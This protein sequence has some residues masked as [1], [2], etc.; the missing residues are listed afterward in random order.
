MFHDEK[1]NRE[2]N[3]TAQ[4][5]ECR[6]ELSQSQGFAG[7]F[8]PLS[9][10]AGSSEPEPLQSLQVSVL[11]VG[12]QLLVE[13]RQPLGL[14]REGHAVPRHGVP[15]PHRQHVALVVL[16][17]QVLQHSRVVD[18]GVQ[19]VLLDGAEASLDRLLVVF[20][21]KRRGG[22]L[23]VCPQSADVFLPHV[24]M[25]RG[26]VLFHDK[27]RSTVGDCSKSEG[28]FRGERVGQS[29]ILNS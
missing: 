15:A 14:F 3:P 18:E 9:R 10:L 26:E 1:H 29:G 19:L 22:E 23:V 25:H 13:Q 28:R 8:L 16:A 7:R 24:K 2:A 11:P 6:H 21:G 4:E 27:I 12:H 20:P 5:E 17:H